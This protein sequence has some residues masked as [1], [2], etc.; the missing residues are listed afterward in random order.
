MICN[1]LCPSRPILFLFSLCLIAVWWS[2]TS[3]FVSKADKSL[4]VLIKLFFSFLLIL[5][6][7]WD[8][9]FAIINI[10]WRCATWIK[11]SHGLMPWAATTLQTPSP[12]VTTLPPAM[13]QYTLSIY[14]ASWRKCSSFPKK[15]INYSAISNATS[16]TAR[17]Q[18]SVRRPR[19]FKRCNTSS[20]KSLTIWTT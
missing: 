20:E 9:R 16:P 14:G 15:S 8:L 12:I 17:R 6:W 11:T 2:T 5:C 1:H 13:S 4:E 18:S 3:G 19:L 7:F 10:R